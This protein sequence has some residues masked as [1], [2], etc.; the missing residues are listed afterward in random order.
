MVNYWIFVIGSTRP[1]RETFEDREQFENLLK[2]HPYWGLF[3]RTAHVKNL[4]KGD[5]GVF[6][7]AGRRKHTFIASFELDSKAY[8]IGTEEK[9]KMNP[10]LMYSSFF[11][12]KIKNVR[13]SKKPVKIHKL[14]D[15]LEMTRG[16]S[17]YGYAFQCGVKKVTE[18]DY[19]EITSRFKE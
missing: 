3:L 2:K 6:Y 4:E 15:L 11:C 5:K 8:G 18:R 9:N 10:Y 7:L 1:G 12:V 16:K 13:F 19:T 17:S 14:V